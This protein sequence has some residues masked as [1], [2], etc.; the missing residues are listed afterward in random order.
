[1]QAHL[2]ADKDLCCT[3]S[4]LKAHQTNNLKND[5]SK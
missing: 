5:L 2:Q 3:A 1:M 4:L